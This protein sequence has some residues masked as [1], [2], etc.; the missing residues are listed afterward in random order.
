[1]Q[2][3]DVHIGPV[4][5]STT[6]CS[7]LTLEEARALGAAL[8]DAGLERATPKMR[9]AYVLE[10]PGPNGGTAQISF[11]PYLPDGQVTCSVCG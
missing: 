11:E 3:G 2:P 10:V 9:L 5:L 8:D 7:D 6:L 4:S 1:M